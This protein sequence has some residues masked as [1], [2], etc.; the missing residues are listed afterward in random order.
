M[1]NFEVKH[2]FEAD[3]SFLYGTIFTGKAKDPKH[4]SRNVCIF[5][6][7]EVDR[8]PT[9]S[10]VSAR[11]AIHRLK[12]ELA[13]NQEITIESILDTTM[14]VKVIEDCSFGPHKAVVPEVSGTAHITGSNRFWFDPVDPLKSGFIF[15]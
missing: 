1:E 4:H 10:G 5:A 9:G 14:S 8:S 15:R 2:P 7:G 6:E 13:I 11:A 3:L 12:D